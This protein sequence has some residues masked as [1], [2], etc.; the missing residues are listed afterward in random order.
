MIKLNIQEKGYQAV[1]RLFGIVNQCLLRDYESVVHAGQYMLSRFNIPQFYLGYSRYLN[2]LNLKRR[3]FHLEFDSPITFAA[4][5]SHL[6][7][8]QFWLQLGCGGG[9]LKTIKCHPEFGNPRPRLQQLFIN[10]NEHLLNALGLPGPG[11][12][13][14]IEQV[15]THSI[16]HTNRPLGFSIGGH[17]LAEYKQAIDEVLEDGVHLLRQPYIELNISCPNTS[18]GQSLHDNLTGLEALL[19]YVR[20]KNKTIVIVIKVSPDA[21]D[22]NLCAIAELAS[23]VP[24]VTI[25]A[26][27]TQ[28][29]RL[30]EVGLSEGK[31][32]IGGGGLSGP[33]LF[34]RTLAMA[35]VL[36]PFKL[37]LISTGGVSSVSQVQALL[38]CNVAVVGIA[39][40][41]VK[42]PF[43]IVKMNQ[44]LAKNN[45]PG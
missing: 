36:A 38:D 9:C 14:L 25:N 11:V 42:N 43:S 33:L 3:V 6:D 19:T 45:G 21:N 27:N 2:A 28:F 15:A 7:S 34:E 13:G 24:F 32:S 35:R 23:S 41:L 12:T 22:A 26:G 31:I 8:L 37:P 39:T 29:K 30:G 16:Q 40:Q 17:E 1:R 5:E 44:T 4:F 10:G 20:E 18:T